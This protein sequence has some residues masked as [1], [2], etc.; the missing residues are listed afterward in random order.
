[1]ESATRPNEDDERRRRVLIVA[2]QDAGFL[3]QC[4]VDSGYDASVSTADNAESSIKE[5]APDAAVVEID[6]ERSED[7]EKYFALARRLRAEAA[8][9]ALPLVFVYHEDKRGLRNFALQVGADDYFALTIPR[10]ELQARMDALFW[11]VE[12]GRRSAS[13]IGDQR[14]EIDNFMVMLEAVRADI[15][16]GWTG[17]LAILH[18]AARENESLDKSVRDK[19]LAEAHGFLKLNLRRADAVA[20]YGP[21]ALLIYFPKWSQAAA[22]ASLNRLR[23]EFEKANVE[24]RIAAGLASFPDDGA[25]LESLISKAETAAGMIEV[26]PGET[27]PVE[28]AQAQPEP[29]AALEEPEI[30]AVQTELEASAPQPSVNVEEGNGSVETAEQAEEDLEVEAAPEIEQSEL[31]VEERVEGNETGAVENN[32]AEKAARAIE[33]AAGELERRASGAIM[34][35]RL[36]L[37]VSDSARMAQ[38]NSL[39]RAAGYEARAA[40]DAK[41]AL[42]LLR[43]ERPDLLLLDYELEGMNGLEM[44]RR[45][46][47]QNR[48]QLSLPVVMLLSRG[49]ESEGREAI[50]LGA[51][52]VV[53]MPY[54]P[55]ELLDSVRVAGKLD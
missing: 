51:H 4:F 50:E 37:T 24:S 11:R 38:I 48:G 12:A 5:F 17:T 36:L 45:L 8:T 32:Q 6:Q 47:S 16:A 46:R 40:F 52:S 20:F 31:R 18:A 43:I 39:V 9:Y 2:E 23:E 21:T 10:S 49:R 26:S 27:L 53:M 34:P 54:D 25:D 3:Q 28:E 41:H 7:E 14:L 44:L 33:A 30:V 22:S 55:F 29:V 19:T 35:R 13:V 1:M 42:D 15:R